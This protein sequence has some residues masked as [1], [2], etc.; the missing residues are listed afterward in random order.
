MKMVMICWL[1]F[2]LSSSHELSAAVALQWRNLSS[3]SIGVLRWRVVLMVVSLS[4]SSS[5][6][7]LVFLDGVL[8]F[9]SV[10]SLWRSVVSVFSDPID[11]SN[12]PAN[13]SFGEKFGSQHGV[14][15]FFFPE[16]TFKFWQH[17]K[18]G[19][20]R[21]CPYGDRNGG[22]YQLGEYSVK[23]INDNWF[24]LLPCG[25][26]SGFGKDSVCGGLVLLMIILISHNYHNG[27]QHS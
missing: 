2:F 8:E 17:L 22:K 7:W 21:H 26:I 25:S 12:F 18:E 20:G 24:N 4:I 10:W 5:L 15:F 1:S 13:I 16:D 14:V 27:Q 3:R 23:N 9:A 6:F 19:R 11:A